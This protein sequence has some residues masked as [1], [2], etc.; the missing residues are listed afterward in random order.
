MNLDALHWLRPI[1]LLGVLPLLAAWWW[2]VRQHRT[3]NAWE[4]WVDPELQPYVLSDEGTRSNATT[5][6]LFTAWLAG[7][8]VLAGPVWEQQPVPVF[9][10]RPAIVLVVDVSPSMTLDDL[11]PSRM[12]RAVFKISDFLAQAK[13]V[14]VGLLVFAERP[15]VVSPLTDDM[16]T[17]EAF[18]PS[19]S[20]ELAPV[21]GSQLHLAITKAV[22]LMGQAGKPLGQIVVLTDSVMTKL[23][24][25]A[26]R[27]ANEAGYLVSILG[28]GTA[29]G[30]P[31]RNPDGSFVR[32]RSGSIIV[33]KV[34][35]DEL[36][37]V[38]AAGGGISTQITR[39]SDDI[40]AV[41]SLSNAQLAG[42]H[43]D[44]EGSGEVPL[45][46]YWVEYGV[47]LLPAFLLCA[48][49]LFRRGLAL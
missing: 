31:L 16:A 29:N 15:Y 37:T 19:V 34:D 24:I 33:P 42:T 30:A 39:G 32:D 13:G 17:L 25:D 46:D 27:N 22:E 36:R 3:V 20:T 38:A 11:P 43:T 28:V 35:I 26:A 45:A 21:A 2:V 12:Q 8:L 23:E 7:L 41:L 5:H 6:T 44:G 4:S 18:L 48:L 49:G 10:S 47:W 14:E 9:E 40:D 1:W